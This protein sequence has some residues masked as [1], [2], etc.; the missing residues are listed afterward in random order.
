LGTNTW[1]GA[2]AVPA[3]ANDAQLL[4]WTIE[5]PDPANVEAAGESLTR[6]GFT[7]ERSDDRD[8]ASLVTSDP[9]GTHILL[10]TNRSK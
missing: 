5:L 9:W 10:T 6:S 7:V 8:A 1:A 3:T 4:E 2:G